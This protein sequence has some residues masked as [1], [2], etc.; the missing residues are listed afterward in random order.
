MSPMTGPY[1]V[2]THGGR[3]ID[4][5]APHWNRIDLT[6]MAI[7]LARIP[8]YL[9]HT[10]EDGAGLRRC[11]G[12]V[13]SV[14]QHG[15]Y[16]RDLVG[17]WCWRERVPLAVARAYAVLHDGHEYLVGDQI[18]PVK[19]LM[20]AR[21]FDFEREV[22]EPVQRAIHASFVLPEVPED[23]VL[24]VIAA[25]DRRAFEVE[26]RLFRGDLRFELGDTPLPS[27]LL[28]MAPPEAVARF[29]EDEVRADLRAAAEFIAGEISA[30][31]ALR[32]QADLARG[33][34]A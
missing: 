32:L 6:D 27:A 13:W 30:E 21:G 12:G 29:F 28:C 2:N 33:Q 19:R 10:S 4:L 24:A 18:S 15:L 16:V 25:A 5:A 11:H 17:L 8:R 9:G 20:L 1:N 34:G 22:A 31:S 7:S 26:S 3:V 14:A 23:G